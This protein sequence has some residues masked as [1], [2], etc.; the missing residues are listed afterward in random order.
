MT[1]EGHN[2]INK[3]SVLTGLPEDAVNKELVGLVE[4]YG[5]RPEELT[6]SDVRNILADYLQDVLLDAKKELASFD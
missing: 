5:I 1:M 6:M 4:S 3:L 2:L